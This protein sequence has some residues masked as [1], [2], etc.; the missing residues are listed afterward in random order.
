LLYEVSRWHLFLHRDARGLPTA[1]P[2]DD[3]R[4]RLEDELF[5]RL[6][7]GGAEPL[8]EPEDSDAVRWAKGVHDACDAL[9]A[10]NRLAAECRGD[11]FAA[12]TG[13]E[14]LL[15]QLGDALEVSDQDQG[16][17][18]RRR[19]AGACAKASDEV[20]AQREALE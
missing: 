15:D 20:C 9:P 11:E 10:F 4:R 17:P 14:S 19:L 6:Y 1:A 7:A 5:E 12:A 13:V 3:A 2:E 8:K 16:R 18:L